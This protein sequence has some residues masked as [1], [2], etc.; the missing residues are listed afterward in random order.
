VS[1]IYLIIELVS[2]VVSTLRKVLLLGR[3]IKRVCM[4]LY[5]CALITEGWEKVERERERERVNLFLRR[6]HQIRDNEVRRKD[7]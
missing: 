3:R 5:L 2:S 4:C 6:I 1:V 7:V